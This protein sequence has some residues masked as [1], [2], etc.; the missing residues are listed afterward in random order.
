MSPLLLLLLQTGIPPVEGTPVERAVFK[1]IELREGTGPAA[2]PGQEYTVHYTGWLKDGTKFDSSV[3]RQQPLQ[4]IQGRR[5]VIAGWDAGFEGM[6]VGGRR[7]L[8]IPY[9]MAY[10]EKGRG[11]IPARAELTFD[12]ELLGVRAVPEEK[13]ALPV[14]S[15]LADA[16]KRLL[17]LARSIP[18][19]RYGFRP[20]PAVRPVR[21]VLVHVALGNRLIHE[22]AARGL[23]GEALRARIEELAAGEHQPR[24]KEEVI[25]LLEESFTQ[26]RKIVEPLRS[27]QLNRETEFFGE[28]N[29]VLG[30]YVRMH[31]HVTEH[32][33]Q[34]IAYTRA[35]GLPLPW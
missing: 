32:L 22:L 7:R 33:G 26:V 9:Q 34:L 35:A 17:L 3:D 21:E 6:K 30:I 10:G 4:F 24:T 8:I 18:A 16:E 31:G 1:T 11:P 25:A 15:A 29:T 28:P 23:K 5:Q 2:E 20:A 12:V 19:E 14:V 27:A 13:P